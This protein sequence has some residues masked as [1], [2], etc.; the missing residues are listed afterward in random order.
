[1]ISNADALE[2]SGW[3]DSPI[4]D[5]FDVTIFSCDVGMAKPDREI[6]DYALAKI[7]VSASSSV[8]VGDGG[9]DEL[10]GA[11]AAGMT[12]VMITTHIAKWRP[13]Q[14]VACRNQADYIIETLEELTG[15]CDE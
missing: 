5:L 13:S 9:S 15:S 4:K 12:S 8:F 14:I 7:G 2:A 11:R 1:L 3:V 10:S 6:F